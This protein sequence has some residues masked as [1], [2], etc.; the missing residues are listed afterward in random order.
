V[1]DPP[2]DGHE[3]FFMVGGI[4]V[5]AD[6]SC[7]RNFLERC[8]IYWIVKSSCDRWVLYRREGDLY[9]REKFKGARVQGCKGW[10]SL[11]AAHVGFIEVGGG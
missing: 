6:C 2:A 9:Q 8:R 3:Q 4:P 11:L 7:V 10:D 5:H 1:N